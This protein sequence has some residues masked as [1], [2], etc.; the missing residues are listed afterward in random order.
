M[1]KLICLLLSIIMIVIT[2]T[3][4]TYY[5]DST[6][7]STEEYTYEETTEEETTTETTTEPTTRKLDINFS[8]PKKMYVGNGMILKGVSQDTT[9]DDDNKITIELTVKCVSGFTDEGMPYVGCFLYYLYGKNNTLLDYT[10]IGTSD[11]LFKI[12][13]SD[14]KDLEVGDE[15][16]ITDTFN[17]SFFN[18]N[19]DDIEKIQLDAPDYINQYYN[20]Y[21]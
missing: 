15:T 12:P 21:S 18:C 9:I 10:S 3:G 14:V 19:A 20:Y 17:L 16:V 4:C 7:E 1:K 6:D 8:T 5:D 13:Y 11:P 2:F